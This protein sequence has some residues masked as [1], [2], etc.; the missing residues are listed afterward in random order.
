MSSSNSKPLLHA[1]MV[2]AA[3]VICHVGTARSQTVQAP[4]TNKRYLVYQALWGFN[5]LSTF[6]GAVDEA[7]NDGFNAI[8]LDI[9]WAYIQRTDG[10]WDFSALDQEV[11]YVVSTK[12]LPVVFMIDL[13]RPSANGG[14]S[15]LSPSDVMRDSSGAYVGQMSWNQ[16]SFASDNF[17][18]KANAFIQTVVS[19]YQTLYPQQSIL[20]VTVSS[21]LAVEAGYPA[22][23]VADY[24][25][26]ANAKFRKWV[27]TKYTSINSVNL[28]WQTNFSDFNSVTPPSDLNTIWNHV[29]GFEWYNFRHYMLKQALAGFAATI[30]GISPSLRYGVQFGSTFDGSS[31]A[32][33]TVNFPD[34]IGDADVVQNDDAPS[35]NH[36]YSMDLLRSNSSNKWIGNEIDGPTA[37]SNP[38]VD[39]LLLATQSFNHG[40]TF[41]SVANWS[42]VDLANHRPLW[43]KIASLLSQPVTTGPAVSSAMTESAYNIVKAWSNTASYQA[44]YQTL[45]NNG[46]NWVFIVRQDDLYN[47]SA[48]HPR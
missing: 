43:S 28:A 25:D 48:F 47:N 1:L 24:S 31:D 22:G 33:G 39:Y 18:Q 5:P 13:R 2:I 3:F 40:A 34:L 4:P 14:D 10:T 20:Y 9:P 23:V 42:Q 11:A 29:S 45:S 30:H 8:R 6:T 41:V 35:Y 46:A 27:Q 19:R 21:T 17:I 12:N 26:T 15:V 44:K 38:D 7:V 16:L 37:S 36:S 32:R